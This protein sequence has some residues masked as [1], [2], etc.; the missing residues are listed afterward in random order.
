MLPFLTVNQMKMEMNC[1]E[2]D[3]MKVKWEEEEEEIN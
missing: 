3:K 2:L 1:R